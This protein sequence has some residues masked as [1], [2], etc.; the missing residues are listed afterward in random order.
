LSPREIH[1]SFA[2]SLAAPQKCLHIVLASLRD[3]CVQ[4]TQVMVLLYVRPETLRPPRLFECASRATGIHRHMLGRTSP[5]WLTGK[6]KMK[7]HNG[8]RNTATWFCPL[9]WSHRGRCTRDWQS[10]LADEL[11]ALTTARGSVRSS[12]ALH[13]GCQ[14]ASSTGHLGDRHSA[15][16]LGCQPTTSSVR[17][18]DNLI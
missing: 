14:V 2:V 7:G 11:T 1:I 3:L 12:K 15:T 9:P 6:H 8:A 13:P 4:S 5:F 16:T 17:D 10:M 18:S